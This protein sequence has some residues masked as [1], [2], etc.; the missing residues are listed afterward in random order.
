[1]PIQVPITPKV[2]RRI[3]KLILEGNEIVCMDETTYLQCLLVGQELAARGKNADPAKI[4]RMYESDKV[5]LTP[6]SPA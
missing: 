2:Y 6:L 1:M 4:K 3:K 5:G